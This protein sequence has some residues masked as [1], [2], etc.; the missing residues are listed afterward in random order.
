MLTEKPA[1]VSCPG[2]GDNIIWLLN[3]Q[4][5]LD[6]RHLRQQKKNQDQKDL[7]YPTTLDAIVAAIKSIKSGKTPGLDGIPAETYKYGVTSLHAPLLK[8]YR[9][10]WTTKELPQQF[11]YSLITA[12]YKKKGDHSDYGNYRSISLLT[13][14]WKRLTKI[15]LKSLQTD[16][17]RCGS[18]RKSMWISC[19][20]LY[21]RHDIHLATITGK[22]C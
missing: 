9:T 13:T 15:V 14:A 11:K 4:K 16:L 1:I 12:I 8:F 21:S 18:F 3:C 20:T 5:L 17:C 10:C 6:K 22:S 2:G 7:A 19:L